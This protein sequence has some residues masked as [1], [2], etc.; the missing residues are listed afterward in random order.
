MKTFIK[1]SFIA[2]SLLLG[3]SLSSAAL[4]GVTQGFPDVAVPSTTY[5]Y[6]SSTGVFLVES[7]GAF[8]ATYN[9]GTEAK[10]ITGS[11]FGSEYQ[12]ALYVDSAGNFTSG[13]AGLQVASKI[14]LSDITVNTIRMYGDTDQGTGLTV[15]GGD[16]LDFGWDGGSTI[17]ALFSVL[18]AQDTDLFTTSLAGFILQD[19]DHT[20]DFSNSFGFS[21]EN[22]F[23]NESD[24]FS[25]PGAVAVSEPSAILLIFGGCLV[26]LGFRRRNASINA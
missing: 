24:T 3:S 21:K 25:V 15:L 17:D 23:V 16:V 18:T 7:L 14:G 26:M 8:S 5:S 10:N 12:F 2:V 13:A 6:D 22:Q 19:T 1:Q 20:I 9:G 4:V 11:G